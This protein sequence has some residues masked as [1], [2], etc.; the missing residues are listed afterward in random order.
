MVLGVTVTG[1]RAQRRLDI[2]LLAGS[3]LIVAL[4]GVG[5]VTSGSFTTDEIALNQGAAATLLHGANPFTSD[6]SWTLSQYGI[7]GG[8]FT[9]DGGLVTSQTYPSLSFLLYVPA[10]ALI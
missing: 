1:E 4:S 6:L 9:L 3:V 8:S 5:A 10:V 2:Y 7:S